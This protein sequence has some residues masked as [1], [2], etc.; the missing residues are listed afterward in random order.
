L[1]YCC[2]VMAFSKG[3]DKPSDSKDIINLLNF[4]QR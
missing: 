3:S 2:L 1:G 4:M